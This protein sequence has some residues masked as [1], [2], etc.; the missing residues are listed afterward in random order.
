MNK[1][2]SRKTNIVCNI[3]LISHTN[4]GI[5]CDQNGRKKG[6]SISSI[7]NK[8]SA[9]EP[10]D[11]KNSLSLY[12]YEGIIPK[13]PRAWQWGYELLVSHQI[14]SQVTREFAREKYCDDEWL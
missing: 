3:N 7:H 1:I 5:I 14:R 4:I 11:A 2:I 6:N 13:Y 8:S 12:N 10:G 9:E